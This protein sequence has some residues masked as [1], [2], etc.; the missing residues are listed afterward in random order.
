MAKWKTAL[1]N[2]RCSM[3]TE[4][5][6]G[7]EA[8]ARHLNAASVVRAV[9][10]GPHNRGCLET[11]GQNILK[12]SHDATPCSSVASAEPDPSAVASFRMSVAPLQFLLLVFA[13]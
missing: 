1:P 12:V 5:L 11:I 10:S 7:A 6:I 3:L 8:A 4:V 13:G 2:W 9:V